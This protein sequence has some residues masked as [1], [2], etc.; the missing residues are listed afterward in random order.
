[1]QIKKQELLALLQHHSIQKGNQRK[2]IPHQKEYL[3]IN[4]TK[5]KND[6]CAEN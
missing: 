1:M 6:V 3:G 4:L 5:N 2:K